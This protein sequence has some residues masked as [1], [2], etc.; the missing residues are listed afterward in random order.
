M[1]TYLV[2]VM[3]SFRRLHTCMA[4]IVRCQRPLLWLVHTGSCLGLLDRALLFLCKLVRECILRDNRLLVE[5]VT[6][7]L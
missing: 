7:S 6:D 2:E 5:R 1:G 4:C 3:A